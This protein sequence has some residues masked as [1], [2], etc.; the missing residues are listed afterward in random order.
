V[1]ELASMLAGEPFG[2]HPRAARPVS[3]AFLRAYNDELDDSRRQDLYLYAARVVGTNE[4]R[5]GERVRSRLLSEWLSRR[6]HRLPL[7][8]AMP[9]HRRTLIASAAGRAMGAN[10]DDEGHRSALELIDRLI[11]AT[12]TGRPAPARPAGPERLARRGHRGGGA[13]GSG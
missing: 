13:L 8:P 5:H 2:D 9:R 6:G 7:I 3:A 10:G 11:R 12:S 1:M 4:G